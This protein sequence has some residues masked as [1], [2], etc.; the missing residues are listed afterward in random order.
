MQHNQLL[1]FDVVRVNIFP[2]DGRILKIVNINPPPVIYFPY[3]LP[4]LELL[5]LPPT[6]YGCSAQAPFIISESYCICAYWLDG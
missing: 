4:Y 5:F 1:E 6:H 3:H 2:A